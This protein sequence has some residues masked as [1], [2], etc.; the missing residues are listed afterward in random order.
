[1]LLHQYYL[2]GLLK[3]IEGPLQFIRMNFCGWCEVTIHCFQHNCLKRSVFSHC[4]F[5]GCKSGDSAWVRLFPG[6]LFCS[7]VVCTL[8]KYHFNYN[9]IT[10]LLSLKL[11]GVGLGVALFYTCLSGRS[12]NPLIWKLASFCLRAFPWII[13]PV[14]FDHFLPSVLPDSCFW[15]SYSVVGPPTHIL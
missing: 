14:Y 3:Q 13:L 5:L 4:R 9:F 12:H 7:F 1:M 15:N 6:S 11:Q 10:D 8:I 2:E